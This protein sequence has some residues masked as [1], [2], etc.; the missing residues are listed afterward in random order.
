MSG[1]RAAWLCALTLGVPGLAAAALHVVII[2]GL[3]GEERYT[4]EFD[5]EAQAVRQASASLTSSGQIRSFQGSAARRTDV[6]GYFKTLSGQLHSNDRVLVYLIGH[7][8]FDGQEYKFNIPGPDLTGHDIAAV[9]NA[10]PAQQQLLIATGSSSGALQELLQRPT[11]VVITA[12]RS[13]NEKNATRFGA[14]LIAA[15]TD[16]AADLD[17]NG[18]ISAQEAF[19]FAARRVKDEYERA[20]Q[21]ASEHPTLAG[22]RASRFTVAQLAPA[23]PA[24][25]AAP[26][27]AERAALNAQIEELRLRKE[28]LTEADYDAQL[29]PLLLQL[30]QLQERIDAA[31]KPAPAAPNARGATP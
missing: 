26:E 20:T 19:D 17:K 15:F 1:G 28:Q 2:E 21:L 12:T 31:G 25:A 29:E 23:A 16:P 8:S 30:A 27:L 7:G 4:R 24:A 9:L 6:L 18:E 14:A 13:G 5:A 10:L 11:R 22:E 3:G